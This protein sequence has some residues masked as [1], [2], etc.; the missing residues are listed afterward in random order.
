MSLSPSS[1]LTEHLT[2]LSDALRRSF[3]RRRPWLE[4]IDRSAFTRPDSLSD[5][6]T[7]IRKN[8]SY[9][10][11]NYISIL[12]LVLA[13]SLLSHPLSLLTLLS[14]LAAWIFVY[15]LRPADQPLVVFSRTFTDRE[16]LWILIGLTIFVVFVTNVVSLLMSA[17]LIGVGMVCVHG[18][19]RDPEDLF[20]DDQDLAGNGLFS[21]VGG[22]SIP[23]SALAAA[24][25]APGLVSHV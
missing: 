1:A 25:A 12:A 6:I 22:G 4:L 2:R 20:L 13:V 17:S 18:A 5:A 9:F 16:A 8:L 14:L 24:A 21:F 3:T 19:F 10:R 11:I 7:R 23:S 15:I